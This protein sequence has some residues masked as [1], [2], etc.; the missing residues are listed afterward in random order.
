M[1]QAY[2]LVWPLGFQRTEPSRRRNSQFRTGVDAALQN[3]ITSLRAFAKDSGKDVSSL[4]VSSNI[5]LLHDQ[6][7][8][9]GVAVYF[10]WDN[11]DCCIPVD[12]YSTPRENLQAIHHVVEAQRTMLR[13]GGLN[14]VRS[15]FR[16]FTALPPP[17]GAD[18]QLAAPWR[19]VL[20]GDPDTACDLISAEARF[21]ELVKETHPDRGGDAGRFVAVADAIKQARDEL[22]SV[23]N[24]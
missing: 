8:D 14:I 13:H 19:Q 2:P 15:A 3:V 17:K 10:R 24:A 9:P 7:K 20:F 16:G 22:G 18:G 11:M 5:T 1:T 12:R 23:G 21:K 4:T 6:P